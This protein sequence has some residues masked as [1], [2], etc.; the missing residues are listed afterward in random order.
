MRPKR[1]VAGA[2]LIAVLAVVVL[3][4]VAGSRSPSPQHPV[5]AAAF[6]AVQV[7]S[8]TGGSEAVYQLDPAARSANSLV[9]DATFSEP[10]RSADAPAGKV[11]LP[12]VSAS[13][14]SGI[15]PP[16]YSMYGL[17]SWYDNGTTALRLP[18]GTLVRI[19]GAGGCVE[20]RV[21]DYGPAAYFRP[22]R[23]AD[24]MPSDFRAICGCGWYA[25]LTSVRVD[26]Y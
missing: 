11:A 14:R 10:G 20:R 16:R 8:S 21:T 18:Y 24:L 12:A 19:C 6:Q 7:D 9:E 13:A 23:V 22:V 3:P 1:L 5:E 26:V 15:K 2:A 25:G 4:Q 17:A